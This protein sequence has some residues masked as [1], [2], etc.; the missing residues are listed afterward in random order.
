MRIRAPLSHA[1]GGPLSTDYIGANWD[2]PEGDYKTRAR[3]VQDHVDFTKGLLWF[4]G[5]DPRVPEEVRQEMQRYGY[6]R[7]EYAD[8]DHW[9]HQLYIRETR[10][11]IGSHVLTEQ[12]CLQTASQENSVGMGSY[13][14]DSHHIQRVVVDGKVVN[15]GNFYLHH[16]A[17]EIPYG[18]L[19]PKKNECVNLLVPVCLSASHVAFGSVRM[20]PVFLILGE[21]AGVA[22]SM[23]IESSIPVQ[24]IGVAALQKKL[25]GYGQRLKVAN[26]R[27]AGK[28]GAV[29]AI[30]APQGGLL[31]DETEAEFTG[32]WSVGR[33]QPL[34]GKA[35]RHDR[36]TPK[37]EGKVTFRFR[38]PSDD[39]YQVRL[40]YR[41]HPNR[42][43]ELPVIVTGADGKPAEA[44]VNQQRGEG[45]LGRYRFEAGREGTVE[46]SNGGTKGVIVIDGLLL[47]P[48]ER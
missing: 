28:S 3:I 26:W 13:A 44:T 1:Y 10:R 9:S 34:V 18:V 43:K 15:E 23:A 37:G 48:V 22:A 33:G 41:P 21:S 29:V 4:I 31:I 30:V 7:D 17:Y 45:D 32:T 6:P 25:L 11:M 14:P 12:D 24:D 8:N 46:I 40:V 20:E 39:E 5:S 36:E 42:V 27:P 19:T 38:V 35:Y 16:H 2:Y 47:S